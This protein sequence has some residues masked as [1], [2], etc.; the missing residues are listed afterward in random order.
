MRKS[1]HL[2]LTSIFISL[3]VAIILVLALFLSYRS[4][5]EFDAESGALI[6]NFI[7]NNIWQTLIFGVVLAA[8]LSWLLAINFTRPLNKIMQ[9][10]KL[11]AE[12]DFETSIH[13]FSKDE[14]GDLAKQIELTSK[15]VAASINSARNERNKLNSLIM[16]LKD[17]IVAVNLDGFSTHI[18]SAA[19]KY[20]NIKE[21]KIEFNDLCSKIGA[22]IAL[23]DL[24]YFEESNTQIREIQVRDYILNLYFDTFK[25]AHGKLSGVVITIHDITESEKMDTMRKEFVA[26]VS[27]ELRTPLT[28]IKGC[29]ETMFAD[30]SIRENSKHFLDVIIGETDRMTQMVKDL[31]NLTTL[32][33]DYTEENKELFDLDELI[34]TVV[35][36]LEIPVKNNGQT[37]IYTKTTEIPEILANKSQIQQLL[38][39]IISNAMKYSPKETGNIEVY[40]GHLYSNVY[41]KVQ[42]NGIGIPKK[43]LDRIFERFFRVSKSRTRGKSGDAGGTGLGLSIA[44]EI[45]QLHKG[46]LKIDSEL[47][48]GTEVVITLPTNDE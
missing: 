45:V 24:I 27:H 31:L 1:I 47:N 2:K 13:V 5:R 9:K 35:K 48:Q 14:F 3:V 4:I 10:A 11:L 6:S 37:L 25:D 40:A 19:R 15:L 30:D 18:N 41:I 38:V 16:R 33:A 46:S 39:N 26:N 8:L 32:G 34:N 7:M 42:D 36:S 17:G 22:N 20:L 43:Y 28:S 29:A 23:A 44:Q 12:G 21:E